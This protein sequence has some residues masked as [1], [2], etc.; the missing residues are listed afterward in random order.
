[1]LIWCKHFPIQESLA[2]Q[3]IGQTSAELSGLFEK[4]FFR[5][6]PS[7]KIDAFPEDRKRN[8]QK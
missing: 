2:V 3:N 5:Q 8:Q 7:P 6:S 1:M 4:Y